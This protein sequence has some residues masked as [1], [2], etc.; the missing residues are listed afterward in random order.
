MLTLLHPAKMTKP[1]EKKDDKKAAPEKKEAAPKKDEKSPAE[2][3]A[4]PRVPSSSAR[5]PLPFPGLLCRST[6]PLAYGLVYL[7]RN[8]SRLDLR[9]SRAN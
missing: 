1:A 4:S 7:Y 3:A 8:S 9:P 2:K 6:R 5:V